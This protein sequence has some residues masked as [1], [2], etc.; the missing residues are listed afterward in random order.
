[1]GRLSRHRLSP[2]CGEVAIQSRDLRPLDRYFPELDEALVALLPEGSIVD[3]EIVVVGA[4]ASTST[5]CSSACIRRRRA[6]RSSRARRQRRSSLSICSPLAAT[7][8]STVAGGAPLGARGAARRGA[9]AALPDA[10]DAR[11]RGRRRLAPRV[12]RRGPRRRHRQAARR[13]VPAGQARDAEDQARAHRRLRRRG[14]SLA[15]EHRGR[16]PEAIGSLL[17][18]LYDDAGV[19]HHVGVTSSFTMD[20]RRDLAKELAPLRRNALANHPW[21][22]WAGQDADGGRR[23]THAGRE[24]PLE[25]RQGPLVA[26][27]S[28]GARLRGQV[29]PSSG[30]PLPPRDD[31]RSLARGQA[32]GAPAATTSSRSSRRSH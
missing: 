16:R 31:L 22:D 9:T 10:G 17:L 11:K 29:R 4:K 32:S 8:S 12:R 5:R 20:V 30:R 18:G 13:A 26:A 21:R 7:A 15:Q 3:G 27:A 19:L 24:Q 28:A 14:L 2:R 1:M 23:P 6:S 25:R